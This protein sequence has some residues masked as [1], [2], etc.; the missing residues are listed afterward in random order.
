MEYQSLRPLEFTQVCSQLAAH[1]AFSVSETL[2]LELE[3]SD[4]LARVMTW[5]QETT[6]ARKLLD[7][8]PQ[9][10]I[11]SARDVRTL[12]RVARVGGMVPA[13]EFLDLRG[14]LLSARNMR[15][16]ILRAAESFPRLAFIAQGLND[17]PRVIDE[18]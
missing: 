8:Q 11:G 14:T 7:Q 2:A 13:N 18:I 16:D 15:K 4:D 3:P 10:S 5:Q 17:A 6:E 1:A 9:L 12:T